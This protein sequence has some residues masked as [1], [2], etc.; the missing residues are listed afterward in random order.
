MKQYG[1]STASKS[2][3]LASR[4]VADSYTKF[5]EQTYLIQYAYV[6][7]DVSQEDAAQMLIALR[8]SRQGA[9]NSLAYCRKHPEKFEQEP[10]AYA[11]IFTSTNS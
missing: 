1:V 8:F 4:K 9:L 11:S 6:H 7:D 10:K 3:L 5:S 2:Q